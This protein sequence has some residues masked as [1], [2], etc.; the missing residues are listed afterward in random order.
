MRKFYADLFPYFQAGRDAFQNGCLAGAYH[1]FT[2]GQKGILF[3]IYGE[4][5]ARARRGDICFS[6]DKNKSAGQLGKEPLLQITAQ[7]GADVSDA[8][9]AVGMIE[10]N[11]GK[12]EI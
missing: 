9:F 1:R 3:Q 12:S 8:A 4:H 7:G 6:G 5:N 2:A 10:I 11:F